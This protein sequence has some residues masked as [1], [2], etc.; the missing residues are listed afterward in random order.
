MDTL[1]KLLIQFLA[2]GT[3]MLK[4][5]K[6]LSY[7]NKTFWFMKNNL[8]NKIFCFLNAKTMHILN[9]TSFMRICRNNNSVEVNF[10][11]DQTVVR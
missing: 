4:S 1:L 10:V 2:K 7:K 11:L 9:H 3:A 8:L 6:Y 5:K